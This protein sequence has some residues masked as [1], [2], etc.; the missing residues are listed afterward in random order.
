MEERSPKTSAIHRSTLERAWRAAARSL[1]EQVS[2]ATF[3]GYI[4]PIRPLRLERDEVVLGVPSTFAREWLA[5][6]HAAL[7]QSA[8]E[9]ALARNLRVRFQVLSPEELSL[10]PEFEH[11]EPESTS[12]TGSAPPFIEHPYRPS[13][14]PPLELY[15]RFTFEEFV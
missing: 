9:R 4:R 1:A 3:E 11:P 2:K 13:W 7:I 6:R 12:D 14:I 10:F 8:L 5:S 15:P